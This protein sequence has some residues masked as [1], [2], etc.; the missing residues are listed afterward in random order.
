MNQLKGA[1]MIREV[2][3][4]G[5]IAVAAITATINIAVAATPFDGPWSLT[6]Y[7]K[8]GACEPSYQFDVYIRNGIIRHPNLVRFKGR[9]ALSGEVRASVAVEAKYASGSGRL[10]RTSG[11]GNWAGYADGA[12]CSGI[13]T[14]TR[15]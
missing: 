3:R 13:W 9:V 6:F 14:A 5:I 2:V 4:A 15:S 12:R 8:R 1:I 11:R 7:T 10:T